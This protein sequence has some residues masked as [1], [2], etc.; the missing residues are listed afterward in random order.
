MWTIGYIVAVSIGDK[1]QFGGH[2]N[3][4]A[5]HTHRET[6]AE[7]EVF[8]KSL[9]LIEHA[10]P[11][12]IFKNLNA[13]PFVR[14]VGFSGLIIVILQG[15]K[16]SP[17]IKTKSNGFPDVGLRHEGLDLKTFQNLHVGDGFIRLEKGCVAGLNRTK[18]RD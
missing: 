16:T 11:I 8:C 14:T 17:K 1:D 5:A 13:V 2:A 4:Y 3:I 12:C 15:P 18:S 7:C 9:L 6:G 10:I